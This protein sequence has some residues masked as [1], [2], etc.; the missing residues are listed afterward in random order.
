MNSPAAQS[1]AARKICV[2]YVGFTHHDTEDQFHVFVSNGVERR[3]ADYLPNL[4]SFPHKLLST[5][6]RL[7]QLDLAFLISHTE[8][9]NAAEERMTVS[10]LARAFYLFPFN[11]NGWIFFCVF[12]LSRRKMFPQFQ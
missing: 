3:L 9:V 7:S 12:V 5:L 10:S 11:A 2:K 4:N 6:L 1:T 8:N